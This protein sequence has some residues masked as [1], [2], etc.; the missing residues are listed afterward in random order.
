M[1]SAS[2]PPI[3]Q[4]FTRTIAERSFVCRDGE[5]EHTVCIEFGEPSQDVIVMNGT[6]WRCPLRITVGSEST[7]RSIVGIDSLQA[8]QLAM[9]LARAELETFAVRP[10]TVLIHLDEEVDTAKPNWQND[11]L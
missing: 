9:S 8:L 7:V 2:F 11:L 6:D 10:G 3:P 5:G 4:D 1:P